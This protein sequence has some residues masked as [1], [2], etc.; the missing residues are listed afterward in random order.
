MVLQIIMPIPTTYRHCL[1]CEALS[2]GVV[3]EK[4]RQEMAAEYPADFLAEFERLMGWI[5]ELILRFG[6]SLQVHVVDPWS[7][8]GLWKC[9]RYGVYR[10]PAFILP[11]GCKVVGW[12]REALEQALQEAAEPTGK[13]SALNSRYG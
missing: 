13:L 9:L 1:S 7:L 6:P 4:A 8:E 5:N 11:G 3:G 2:G 10:Y 12:E